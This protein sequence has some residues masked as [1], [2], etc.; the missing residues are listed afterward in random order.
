MAIALLLATTGWCRTGLAQPTGQEPAEP[1][2]LVW[3]SSLEAAQ[4]RA[5]ETGRLVLVHFGAPWCAPCRRMEQAFSQPGF[6]REL[7]QH[8]VAV[9]LNRDHYPATARRLGVDAIPAD[10]V[11]TPD[12]QILHRMQGARSADRYV[13]ALLAVADDARR[14]ND[15][16][17]HAA[18]D[19]TAPQ[20]PN[21]ASAT[22]PASPPSPRGTNGTALNRAQQPSSRQSG[23]AWDPPSTPQ[24]PDAVAQAPGGRDVPADAPP[25]GR[26]PPRPSRNVAASTKNSRSPVIRQEDLPP[27]SPPLALEGYC[28]VTLCLKK[29]WTIGDVRYGAVHR[30]RTYLFA[31]PEEQQEFLANPDRYSPVLKGH[32]PVLA[33]DEHRLVP[34]ER[35]YGLFC[36]GRIYLFCCEQTLQTFARNPQRYMAE[37]V[38]ALR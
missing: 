10:V 37:A 29:R 24:P 28:P 38:Q 1:S 14:A 6:G 26:Q 5:A 34:G 21:P 35:R 17:A 15:A 30:G 12:G 11:L 27:D 25:T 16:V 23:T 31:G 9:K 18:P 20:P 33:L 3:E 19:S 22:A 13:A 7:N 4:R 36:G 32:D 2:G 8:Y